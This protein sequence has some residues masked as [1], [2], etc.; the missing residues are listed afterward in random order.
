MGDEIETKRRL[1]M[2]RFLVMGYIYTSHR[3][4]EVRGTSKCVMPTTC[5][6]AFTWGSAIA[7]LFFLFVGTPRMGITRF[8]G[9]VAKAILR[10]GTLMS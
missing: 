6:G 8:E 5:C 3:E 9:K 1:F 4:N 7:F 10:N 2:V